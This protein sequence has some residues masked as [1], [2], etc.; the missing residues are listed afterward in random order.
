MTEDKSRKASLEFA[1]MNMIAVSNERYH[2]WFDRERNAE[3]LREYTLEEVERIIQSGSLHEQQVLSRTYFYKNGYYAQIL[4]Y[5]ST[6]LKYAG[7]LIPHP[8]FGQSL[9]TPHIQ[10]R[11]IQVLDYIDKMRLPVFLTNCSLRVLIDGAY[12]GIIIQLDKNKFTVLDLPC[13][14][15]CSRFKDL[16]GNDVVEFD[17]SYFNT[18]ENEIVRKD[19]LSIY[20]KIIKAAYDKY[21]SGKSNS[22]YVVLPAE[23]CIYFSFFTNGRPPFLALIPA[24]IEYDD[25]VKNN[26]DKD[27]EEIKKIIV[28]QIPHLSDGRLLFEPQEAE[29]IHAGAVG[30]MGKNPN[31]DVLTTYADVDAIQ[32]QTSSDVS[33]NSTLNQML[34]NIYTKSGTS[35]EIFSATSSSTLPISLK[36]DLAMMMYLGNKY[37]IFVTNIL[38][39]LYQNSNVS[40]KYQILPISYF[41]SEDYVDKS[42]KLAGSGYSYLL[43]ALALGISQKDLIDLKDLENN[44]LKLEEVL[45]PLQS[46]YTQSGE[47]G[48]P[49]K[50]QEEKAEQTIANENSQ[51]NVAREGSE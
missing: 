49:K 4:T 31:V 43:P 12:Y 46:S 27:A 29:E 26:R 33:K 25:A 45:I 37:S 23:I 18:I 28:Q 11:Y 51:D 10:K 3:A 6:L 30:M 41:N 8:S 39:F 20:P 42:F 19:V 21:M 1:K 15:C 36:K 32:S 17:V 16:D 9:S 7:I 38:N 14:Y 40:F 34:K 48:R 24:T 50:A 47:V 13:D 35:A 2:S 44:M 22:R 5:Y